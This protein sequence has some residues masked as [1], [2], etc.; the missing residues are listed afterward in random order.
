[1]LKNSSNQ[2]VGNS[3]VKNSV[4]LIGHHVDKVFLRHQQLPW[5]RIS[6]LIIASN[7]YY[8]SS[9]YFLCHS[10]ESYHREACP[11]ECG[12]RGAGFSLCA[13]AK[14]WLSFRDACL[15]R[16]DTENTSIQAFDFIWW[17]LSPFMPNRHQNAVANQICGEP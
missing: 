16:H 4:T 14:G 3:D 1:M 2:V 9:R 17:H 8:K 7:A 11:R 13:I 5:C 12:E 15:R 6:S 10:C